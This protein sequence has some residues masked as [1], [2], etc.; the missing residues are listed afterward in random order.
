[1]WHVPSPSTSKDVY[2]RARTN[3]NSYL[4]CTCNKKHISMSIDVNVPLGIRVHCKRPG[5]QK[6]PVNSGPKVHLCMGLSGSMTPVWPVAQHAEPPLFIA[7]E[8]L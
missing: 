8:K 1:M 5:P 4:H 3:F 2:F 6:S 7:N